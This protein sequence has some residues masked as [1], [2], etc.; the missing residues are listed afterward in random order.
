MRNILLLAVA[1]L[2]ASCLVTPGPGSS[3]PRTA[4]SAPKPAICTAYQASCTAQCAS[5]AAPVLDP[6]TCPV[7]CTPTADGTH[8]VCTRSMSC[9]MAAN[10]ERVVEYHR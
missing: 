4:S 6:V 7:E 5:L 8:Q 1:S 3:S 2:L 9:T 10:T